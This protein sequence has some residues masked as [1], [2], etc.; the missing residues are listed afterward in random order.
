MRQLERERSKE[1]GKELLEKEFRRYNTSLSREIKNNTI[2]YVI[3]EKRLSS[4][5]DLLALVGYGKIDAKHVVETCLPNV[6]KKEEVPVQKQS[7]LSQLFDKIA[8]R[9]NTGIKVDGINDVLL[10]YARCCTPVKGDPIIGFVTRG[11]GISIH[12][13]DCQKIMELDSERRITV[14]WID[15]TQTL[16]PIALKVYSEDREGMLTDLSSVFLKLNI[17]IS[18]AKCRVLDNHK[19]VNTFKCSVFDIDQ[20]KLLIRNLSLVQGVN[21]VKCSPIKKVIIHYGF[22]QLY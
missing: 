15:E 3:K 19:A 18:E 16:R 13:R 6:E 12:R 20:L 8:K 9:S 21:E 17:N 22:V 14:T 11:R 2:E 1:I 10:H 4:I 5:E 7:R